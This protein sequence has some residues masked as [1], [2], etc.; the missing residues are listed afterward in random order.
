MR[1]IFAVVALLPLAACGAK[2][3]PPAAPSKPA[4]FQL[5]GSITLGPGDFI[6]NDNPLECAGKDGYG[7]MKV[8]AQAVVTDAAGATLALGSIVEAE[9]QITDPA[10]DGSSIAEG[11]KLR[12]RVLSVPAGQKF[13]GVEVSHRGRLQYTEAEAR[14]ELTL[15]LN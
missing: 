13:Y 9:P 1:R 7:D 3:A 11:C 4:V 15:T 6:W 10:D 14:Q 8:G 5:T 2:Q 12:F